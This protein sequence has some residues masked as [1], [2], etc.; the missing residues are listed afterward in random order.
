MKKTVQY[1]FLLLVLLSSNVLAQTEELSATAKYL[2]SQV[3]TGDYNAILKAGDSGDLTLIPYLKQL[4]SNM[5][6]RSNSNS[7]AYEAHIALAKL[8]DNEALQQILAGIDAENPDVQDKAMKKLS[9]VGGKEAFKKFHQLL[10]DTAPRE[11]PECQKR[12]ENFKKN[13]PE[14]GNCGFCC[15][16]VFFSKSVSAILLLSDMVDNPPT[17]R[18]T[19][20]NLEKNI[21]LWKEWFAKNKHLIE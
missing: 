4:A 10:D 13:H 18:G 2:K 20:W 15:D 8:G 1:T 6:G 19:T 17:K 14:G 3:E 11:N 7:S 5:K 9:L 12:L 21:Q 16:V